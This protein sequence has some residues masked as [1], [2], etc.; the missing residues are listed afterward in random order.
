VLYGLGVF[1]A[2]LSADKS[3]ARPVPAGSRRR[4]NRGNA[5]ASS[6]TA[7]HHLN[8]EEAWRLVTRPLG[9]HHQVEAL[10]DLGDAL[11]AAGRPQDAQQA[12]QE[13]LVICETLQVPESA[14]VR[15]RL[16]SRTP[17]A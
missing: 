17:S 16:A 9:L 6:S 8:R 10:R 4:G 3:S 7:A 14:E 2:S 15:Q 5:V 13:A 1:L 12:W 11:L